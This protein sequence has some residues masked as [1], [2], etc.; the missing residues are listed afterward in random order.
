[1]ISDQQRNEAIFRVVATSDPPQFGTAFLVAPGYAL[2]CLHVVESA[3]KIELHPETDEA[4]VDPIPAEVVDGS[5]DEDGDF[6]LL[7]FDSAERR[8]LPLG[9]HALLVGLGCSAQGYPGG[10]EQ[11]AGMTGTINTADRQRLTFVAS[12]LGSRRPQRADGFSGSPV[13][14]KKLARVVGMVRDCQVQDD[15]PVGATI[16][17]VSVAAILDNDA[18]RKVVDQRHEADRQRATKRIVH[19]LA[20]HSDFVERLASV[21][22]SEES[23]EAVAEALVSQ[24]TGEK[25]VAQVYG[26][27]LGPPRVE[28]SRAVAVKVLAELLPLYDAFRQPLDFLARESSHIKACDVS[29]ATLGFAEILAAY[30]DGRACSFSIEGGELVGTARILA[31]GKVVGGIKIAADDDGF[32]R[33][34]VSVLAKQS[35][36]KEDPAL[37]NVYLEH[38]RATYKQAG[39][40]VVITEQFRKA[41][42]HSIE[43][44]L[45]E[46]PNLRILEFDPALP[47]EHEYSTLDP[48]FEL[49]RVTVT[50][51]HNQ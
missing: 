1:M 32:Y 47:R 13:Y 17:A 11:Y 31:E 50:N 10:D 9:T 8:A 21:F 28:A 30:L 29:V 33:A 26:A 12:E 15:D 2:T 37:L 22:A 5:H 25:I 45:L 19:L 39:T 34:V 24:P 18:I 23:V 40:Y 48:L 36:R 51:V 42:T 27:F 6:V 44:L 3:D 43:R 16:A 49:S 41:N 35:G 46:L 20:D 14:S 38:R 7:A 4:H